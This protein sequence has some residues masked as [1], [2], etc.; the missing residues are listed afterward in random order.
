MHS[1]VP[2][3]AFQSLCQVEHFLHPRVLLCGFLQLWFFLD[4]LLQLD[5]QHG[6][7]HLRD[8]VHIGEAHIQHA[9]HILDG[10]LGS[11]GIEGDD[12]G[13]LLATVLLGHI[14]DHLTSPPRA[15]I[16]IHVGKADALRVQEA[17]KKKVV[18]QRINVCNSE[19][20]GNQAASGRPSP[21]PH[22]NATR[23]RIA[24]EVPHNQEVPGELHALNQLDL[25]LQPLLI[26]CQG[27]L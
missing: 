7:N 13:H 11:Q 3:L 2:R 8:P 1:C 10:G 22:R 23:A 24:N 26:L 9:P 5:V 19:A 15:K 4:R 25:S 18:L 12:L 27:V 17:F 20:E 21:R 16:H 14:L 6:R